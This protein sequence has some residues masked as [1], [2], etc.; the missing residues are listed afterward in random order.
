[1]R[2]KSHGKSGLRWARLGLAALT[3]LMPGLSAWGA[4]DQ[5]TT[6]TASGTVAT[7]FS[8]AVSGNLSMGSLPADNA[9]YT[10]TQ[11]NTVTLK[12]N[13]DAAWYG[14]IKINA[15]VTG[16]TLEVQ[17][18]SIAAFTALTATNQTFTSDTLTP[19]VN[20]PSGSAVILS[21]RA[22]SDGT[23]VGATAVSWTVTYT[24]TQ[25]V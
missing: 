12:N 5:T 2:S 9:T 16:A 1:M 23:L 17:G 21:Y 20:T 15:A 11:T 3:M 13:E 25:L 22:K 14:K 8:V 6:A 19:F 4:A 10:A 18:G 7:V 24:L